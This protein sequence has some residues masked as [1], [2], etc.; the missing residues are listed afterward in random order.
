VGSLGTIAFKQGWYVYAGSA[1]KNLSQRINRHLR[2]VR[3]QRHW[4]VDYLTPCA[5]KLKALPIL[6]YRNLEC[7]LAADLEELGGKPVPGFGCSDCHCGSHLYYFAK[8]PMGNRDFVAM[9]LRYRH[10]DG[11][12]GRTE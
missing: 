4:H 1:R 5:G 7:D 3:K 10:V 9:L 11:L 8:A 6:S 12:K 2:K